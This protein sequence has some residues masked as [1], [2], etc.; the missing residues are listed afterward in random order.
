MTQGWLN[1]EIPPEVANK[2]TTINQEFY[3]KY[4]WAGA[5]LGTT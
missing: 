2:L 5:K 1:G 3:E 4:P